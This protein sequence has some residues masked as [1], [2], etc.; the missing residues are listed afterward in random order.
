MAQTKPKSW[1]DEVK[2]DAERLTK[3]RLE[4][5]GANTHAEKEA[6]INKVEEAET[7]KK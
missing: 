2:E 5:A 4:D 7:A 3:R 1:L 6:E